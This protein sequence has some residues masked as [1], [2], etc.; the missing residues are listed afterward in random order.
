[1]IRK[2]LIDRF[3][4]DHFKKSKAGVYV[5]NGSYWFRGFTEDIWQAYAAAVACLDN[6]GGN[7]E[8]KKSHVE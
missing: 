8:N 1:M 6:M 2:T 3:D 7:D 5:D 4:P